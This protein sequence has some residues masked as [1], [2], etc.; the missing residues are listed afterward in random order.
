MDY[1]N[2]VLRLACVADSCTT[3]G[4][5]VRAVL[6]VQGCNRRCPGCIAPE[7]QDPLGGYSV[8]V[9]RLVENLT[10]IKGIEGI[11]IS[12]GEPFLQ[13]GPLAAM[14][15][16]MQACRPLT[17]M[18]YTGFTLQQIRQDGDANQK[19]LLGSVDILVDGPYMAERAT[20]KRWRG[21]DNQIIHFLTPRYA[22]L[23]HQIDDETFAL[24]VQVGG[25]G[26]VI[27]MGIPPPGFRDRFE[28]GLKAR[29][30][31]L[32]CMT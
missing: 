16:L 1:S 22:R 8:T 24:D 6:W 14:I 3:L 26:T 9:Q 28:E 2:T 32:K 23:A 27:W 4:P 20:A 5:G 31:K 30:I 17:V 29:H 25:D 12:G 7:K 21:S 13:A 11:T 15:A 18:V 19:A 10:S